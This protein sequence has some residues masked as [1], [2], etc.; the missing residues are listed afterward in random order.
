MHVSFEPQQRSGTGFSLIRLRHL[1]PVVLHH[2]AEE[3]AR[4]E[5]VTRVPTLS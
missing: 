1:P 3:G 5:V 4:S 2:V